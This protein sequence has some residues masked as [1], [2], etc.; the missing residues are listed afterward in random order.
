MVVEMKWRDL[1]VETLATMV[2]LG[3]LRR[4]VIRMQYLGQLARIRRFSSVLTPRTDLGLSATKSF[5][6]RAMQSGAMSPN[7]DR[8]PP[9]CM[10]DRLHP[11][12]SKNDLSRTPLTHAR[13]HTYILARTSHTKGGKSRQGPLQL[14]RSITILRCQPRHLLCTPTARAPG[15]NT[16]LRSTSPRWLV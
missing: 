15:N 8:Y 16:A 4:K 10:L 3:Y 5:H 2:L 9:A 6:G 13:A 11:I 7:G 1:N 12:A 14:V